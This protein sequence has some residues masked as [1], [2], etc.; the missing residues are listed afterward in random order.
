MKNF[1]RKNLKFSLCGLNCAIC[2]M[3]IG[4]YCP[5]CGGGEG[6][7]SCKIARCGMEKGLEYCFMCNIFPCDKLLDME[8]YDSFITHR[9]QIKDMEKARISGM[10][11]YVSML[12]LKE[13]MLAYLLD[14]YD[15]G[16]KKSFYCM[17]VNLLDIKEIQK[18]IYDF[19]SGNNVGM[20]IK[21]K[22]DMLKDMLMHLADSMD[23]KLKLNKKEEDK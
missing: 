20:S 3:H 6:N 4:G 17:A 11:S 16:R 14:N 23:I 13:R 9:N 12:E 21:Q 18:I 15:D 10:D 7:Q 1:V 19:E 8:K 2:V 22:A 5:G